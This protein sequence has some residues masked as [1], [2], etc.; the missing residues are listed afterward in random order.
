MQTAR[1]F[2]QIV[3]I[4]AGSAK[5]THIFLAGDRLTDQPPGLS[6]THRN[7]RVL[8]TLLLSGK[9]GSVPLSRIF[10]AAAFTALTMFTYPVQRQRLPASARRI[11][12]SVGFDF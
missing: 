10:S 1:R 2:R 3:D 11:S 7:S 5:K 9:T 8:S 4:P 12:R 6:R